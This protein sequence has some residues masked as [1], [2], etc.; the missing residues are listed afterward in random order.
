MDSYQS[1]SE[2]QT[3]TS[4]TVYTEEQ[5][6]SENT[7]FAKPLKMFNKEPSSV[8]QVS[9]LRSEYNEKF[10]KTPVIKEIKSNDALVKSILSDFEKISVSEPEQKESSSFT[11][12]PKEDIEENYVSM[13][14]KRSFSELHSVF[15]KGSPHLE[16]EED[17]YMEMI[18]GANST[19]LSSGCDP[20][21]YEIVCFGKSKNE[22]LY[23]ELTM[24]KSEQHAQSKPELLPDIVSAPQ[25]QSDTKG[26]K[27]DSSDADDEASKDL[28]SLDTPSQPRFSLS[29]SFRPASYYLGATQA[30]PEFQDSSDSELVSPPPIPT[31]SPPMTEYDNN[32]ESITSSL[33]FSEQPRK[34][35]KDGKQDSYYTEKDH[36]TSSVCTFNTDTENKEVDEYGKRERVTKSQSHQDFH[37]YENLYVFEDSGKKICASPLQ[38]LHSRESSK[39]ATTSGLSYEEFVPRAQV[40]A[41]SSATAEITALLPTSACSTP[42]VVLE[43][44]FNA[45]ELSSVS[46]Y[47][48]QQKDD[49]SFTQ[50][51]PYYYSDLSMNTSHSN[52]STILMLNN[53]RESMNGNK[54]DITHIVNPI[55]CNTHVQNLHSPYGV[56]ENTFKLAAE[57]R[58][59]SVDFLNLADK[60]G[61]IDKKNIY[62]SDTLKRLKAVDSVSSLQSNPETRNLYPYRN[63]EKFNRS[64]AQSEDINFRRS[65]SLEGLLENV[66]SEAV[67][68]SP[69]QTN[70]N[71]E[72]NTDEFGNDN[73]EGSYLWEEDAVWRERLRSA[74]QRHTRSL[75]DLDCVC[76]PKK[77]QKKHTRGISRLVTYVND[78]IYNMP[79]KELEKN[80][81]CSNCKNTAKNRDSTFIIDREKLRQWDLMSSAP[82]DGQRTTNT[83]VGCDQQGEQEKVEEPGNNLS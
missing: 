79:Q 13:T 9:T 52:S 3:S 43:P 69:N 71:N 35:S 40:D 38:I 10:E 34:S 46:F 45:Q 4:T 60:S 63:K 22:P 77:S 75:D 32:D 72:T 66:L 17:P 78:N 47:F 57:A 37:D 1:T 81:V 64:E 50:P 21:E 15:G 53:Q 76:E 24:Q 74:S 20:Q 49:N 26:N 18:H 58:S 61:Q 51:A 62:E 19:V 5:S 30:T 65:H 11:D 2:P 56:T 80:S 31:S 28:D 41:N 54:R 48:R 29:D 25:E 55:R 44:S 68:T 67:E 70:G 83:V 59:V 27:S 33:S 82:A 73:T 12:K 23:M 16:I 39:E 36:D 14:S 8:A 42:T 7:N 6:C